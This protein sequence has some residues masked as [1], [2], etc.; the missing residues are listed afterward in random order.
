M[1][2]DYSADKILDKDGD[3]FLANANGGTIDMGAAVTGVLWVTEKRLLG[4]NYGSA[5][6]PAVTNNALEFAP[7]GVNTGGQH[8][9]CRPLRSAN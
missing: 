5:I 6:W 9:I 7:P 3:R 4:G 1:Y 2:Y 8:G